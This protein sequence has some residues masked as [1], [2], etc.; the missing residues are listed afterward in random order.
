MGIF[1]DG[2]EAVDGDF[3]SFGDRL[4][5]QIPVSPES[6]SDSRQMYPDSFPIPYLGLKTIN[7]ACVVGRRSIVVRLAPSSLAKN[8]S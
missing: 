2:L 7:L 4:D 8:S 1:L 3:C 6:L 5:R